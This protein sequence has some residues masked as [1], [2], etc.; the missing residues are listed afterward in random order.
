MS[1]RL[2]DVERSKAELAEKMAKLQAEAD[3]IN[4]QLEEAELK[5]SAALKASATMESQ[6][7]EAQVC[8]NQRI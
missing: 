1:A 6:L 4:N 8:Q 2:S 5:A 3:T 7:Q